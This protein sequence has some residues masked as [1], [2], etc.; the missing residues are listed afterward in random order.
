MLARGLA[1]NGV[2]SL[3]F[4]YAGTGNSSGES[5]DITIDTLVDDTMHAVNWL[6]ARHASDV[7]CVIGVRFGGTVATL[8]AEKHPLVTLLALHTPILSG[9]GYW[10]SLLKSRQ[11]MEVARGGKPKSKTQLI[12]ELT[13][14]GHIEILADLWSEEFV[15]GLRGIDLAQRVPAPIS[16]VMLATVASDKRAKSEVAR[17]AEK[18]RDTEFNTVLWVDTESEFC[19]TP[20][21]D[22]SLPLPYL[23]QTLAWLGGQPT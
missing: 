16:S 18:Y 19:W 13:T 11:V 3:R 6:A 8:V 14:Q 10:N 15:R 7:L 23:Q 12:E 17:L 20:R 21:H 2:S 22:A 1:A 4:H 5:S 9:D